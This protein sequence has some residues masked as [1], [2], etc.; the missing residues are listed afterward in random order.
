MEVVEIETVAYSNQRDQVDRLNYEELKA[1]DPPPDYL[2]EL[3][4]EC[5]INGMTKQ[6]EVADY[7]EQDI[8]EIRKGIKRL[9][10]KLDPIKNKF[11]KMGYGQE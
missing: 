1:H 5:W 2:E 7:L 4:F 6:R 11:V 9:K 10:G 8:K 3:I